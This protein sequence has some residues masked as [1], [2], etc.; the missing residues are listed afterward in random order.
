A[1]THMA[2]SPGVR[3]STRAEAVQSSARTILRRSSLRSL[4]FKSPPS[5]LSQGFE[6]VHLCRSPRRNP[7]RRKG[8]H[9]QQTCDRKESNRVS[10]V[11]TVKRFAHSTLPFIQVCVRTL[12]K[13]QETVPHK[14]SED[15]SPNH[16][17]HSLPDHH[18]ED[19]AVLRAERHP[20]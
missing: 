6:R 3:L 10:S 4:F 9:Q 15:Q 1:V 20:Q 8:D 12:G 5:F 7:A 17:L 18:P 11:N 16:Q 13:P 2:S 14:S 19:V